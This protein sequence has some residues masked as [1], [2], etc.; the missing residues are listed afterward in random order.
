ML[1]FQMDLQM[2]K[3]GR[4]EEYKDPSSLEASSNEFISTYIVQRVWT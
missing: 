2:K 3:L 4:V 1:E